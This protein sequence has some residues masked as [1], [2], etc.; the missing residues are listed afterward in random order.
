MGLRRYGGQRGLTYTE[1]RGHLD[2]LEKNWASP[3]VRY[4]PTRRVFKASGSRSLS[5]DLWPQAAR[6]PSEATE[7]LRAAS[8]LNMI[9]RRR[10]GRGSL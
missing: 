3:M 10:G 5:H 9:R 8:H 4:S 6:S 1:R 7:H 2:L